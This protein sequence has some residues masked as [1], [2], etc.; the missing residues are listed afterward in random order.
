MDTARTTPI[1]SQACLNI[2]HLGFSYPDTAQAV[3]ADL[4]LKL[5]AN[6][7]ATLVGRSGCGKTTLLN[8]LLGYLEASSGRSILGDEP[9][10]SSRER[11]VPVFQV[12]GVLPWFRVTDNVMLESWLTP[13]R[14]TLATD[15]ARAKRLLRDVGLDSRFH[16][17][18]PKQLS[19]GMKK[20]VEIARAL[21]SS[22]SLLLADE[23]FSSLD[24][25]T[26]ELLHALVLK[27]W[28]EQRFTIL[29]TTHDLHEALYLSTHIVVMRAKLPSR[30]VSM[31][32]NPFQGIVGWR[33]ASSEAYCDKYDLIRRELNGYE[34]SQVE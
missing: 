10:G 5:P 33:G 21:F 8:I 9:I 23:P 24:T 22:P 29:L 27:I 20:R 17:V 14:R 12:D 32:T 26:R 18:F 31:H 34:Q 16:D 7:F 30:I 11:I 1:D 28:K 4:S 2:E 15:R 19:E 3:L 13:R 25:E 6:S